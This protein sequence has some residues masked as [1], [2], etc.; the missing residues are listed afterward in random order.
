MTARLSERPT[1]PGLGHSW[2]IA[3]SSRGTGR[4]W[5]TAICDECPWT[6]TTVQR[7]DV[8]FVQGCD[9]SEATLATAPAMPEPIR[10]TEPADQLPLF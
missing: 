2:H 1:R 5:H 8:A 6:G 10:P 7:R 4:Y 3:Q 9:H